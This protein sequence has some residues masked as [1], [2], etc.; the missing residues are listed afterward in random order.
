MISLSYLQI[1]PTLHCRTLTLLEGHHL[2]VLGDVSLAILGRLEANDTRAA[3]KEVLLC[4]P[5]LR[6]V[7]ST[8]ENLVA[9]AD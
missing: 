3:T 8:I 7:G 4:E 5:L 1:C 2:G 6:F 9:S